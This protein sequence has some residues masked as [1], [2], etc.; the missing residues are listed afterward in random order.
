[1]SWLTTTDH[2][3]IGTLYLLTALF[4]FVVGG[5]EAAA[6]RAQLAQPNGTLVSADFYN[7]LFTMHGTTMVFLAI[8]PLSAAFFNWLIPLQ[9]GARDVAL[10]RLNAFSYW[11]YLLG[12]IFITLPI[13]FAVAPN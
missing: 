11:V 13:L 7:Q 9:I 6:I 12:A 1:M 2:K 10:P 4:F 5:L 8:M 3:K